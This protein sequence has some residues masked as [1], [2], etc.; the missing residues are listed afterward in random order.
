[1]DEE[2]K[3]LGRVE[4]NHLHLHNADF[5][6]S[7]C[8]RPNPPTHQSTHPSIHILHPPVKFVS[9]LALHCI[10]AVLPQTQPRAGVCL[11]WGS[12][13]LIMSIRRGRQAKRKKKKRGEKSQHRL[14]QAQGTQAVQREAGSER[15]A[16]HKDAFSC[17]EG[18]GE[19]IKDEE[20]K[21]GEKKEKDAPRDL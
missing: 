4:D 2:R 8:K 16:S 1:M 5:S 15:S 20:K 12:N 6:I 14:G 9:D 17:R 7:A 18:W 3:Q 10:L 19:N 21:G 13:L 11:L